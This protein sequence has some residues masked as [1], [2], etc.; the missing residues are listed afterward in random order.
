V[1]LD[2]QVFSSHPGDNRVAKQDPALM[3]SFSHRVVPKLA[4]GL[5]SGLTSPYYTSTLLPVYVQSAYYPIDQSGFFVQGR[6]GQFIPLDPKNYNGGLYSELSTGF[7]I[8]GKDGVAFRVGLGYSHQHMTSQVNDF[9]WGNRQIDYRFN[10][11]VFVV[12]MRF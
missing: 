11:A 6:M 9:W 8:R 10:R 12:G 5:G 4:V 7:D 3:L 2:V 1:G